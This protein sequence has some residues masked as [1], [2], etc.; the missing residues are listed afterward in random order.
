MS[1][2]SPVIGLT[3]NYRDAIRTIR[4]VNSLLSEGVIHVLVWDN[5]EDNGVSV[6]ILSDKF[7]HDDRVSIERSLV[8]LGFASGVNRGLD[9]VTAHFGKTWVLLLNNDAWLL[10][11]AIAPLVVALEEQIQAVIAYPDINNDGSIVGTVYYQRHTGLLTRRPLPNSL[12]RTQASR[13]QL[14]IAK[15]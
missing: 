1:V 5:S 3:L 13:Q 14:M 10:S 11:D 9:W 4:C 6:S 8:N 2:S 15:L 12:R 7:M